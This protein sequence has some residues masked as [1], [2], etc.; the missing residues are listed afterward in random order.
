M[1]YLIGATHYIHIRMS[2]DRMLYLFGDYHTRTGICPEPGA[3][4]LKDYLHRVISM[5]PKTKY[6]L[7][8]EIERGNKQ[9]IPLASDMTEVYNYFVNNPLPN[10]DL[11]AADTR[12]RGVHTQLTRFMKARFTARQMINNLD[13]LSQDDFLEMRRRFMDIVSRLTINYEKLWEAF[14]Y[15]DERL[16]MFFKEEFSKIAIGP[17]EKRVYLEMISRLDKRDLMYSKWV[18]STRQFRSMSAHFG[19]VLALFQDLYICGKILE[20]S[21]GSRTIAYFGSNHYKKIK[22]FFANYEMYDQCQSD[23]ESSLERFKCLPL[24]KIRKNLR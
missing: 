12:I 24:M 9:S 20:T 2:D 19:A 18:V 13:H 17:N 21:K 4:H 6:N 22:K 3:I 11:H 8:V 16:Y 7:F 15:K 10:L 14:G 5:H 1:K 23:Q